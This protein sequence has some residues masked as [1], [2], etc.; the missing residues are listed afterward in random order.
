VTENNQKKI[1]ETKTRDERV[2]PISYSYT[3]TDSREIREIKQKEEDMN[4]KK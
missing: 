3:H 1:D 2:R 4:R